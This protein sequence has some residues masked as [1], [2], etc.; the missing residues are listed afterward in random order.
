MHIS[1]DNFHQGDKYTAHIA[2]HQ[3]QLR[4]EEKFTNQKYLSI[5]SL[6]TDYLNLENI[7]GSGGNNE[8]ANIVQKKWTFCGGTNHPTEKCL[9]RIIKYKEKARA[10]GDSDRQLTELPPCKRFIC[11]SIDHLIYICPKPSKYNEKK[12]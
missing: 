9:K 6:H 12:K 10:Y 4:R 8:R 5:S 1:L 3:A 7:S 11:Q 2:S